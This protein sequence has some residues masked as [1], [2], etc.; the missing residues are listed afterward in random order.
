MM[1]KLLNPMLRKA[2]RLCN[3]ALLT[4]F[5]ATTTNQPSY[6]NNM[7]FFCEESKG[8]PTTFARREDGRKMPII[9][10]VS[11]YSFLTPLQRCQEVSR[12]FQKSYDNGTLKTIITGTINEQSV[13]CAVVSTNDACT[14][15]T[16]LFTLKRGDNGKTVLERL[17]D[18]R[19]LA[20][21]VIQNQSSDNSQVY[22]DF[23]TY[24]SNLKPE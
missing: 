10:W 17:L 20:G 4:V 9:R 7:K 19:G 5:A 21:S 16:V 18:R 2:A 13:I 12:R 22:I 3:M 8:I 23:E 11:S 14:N 6:A 15:A 24:L 1:Y